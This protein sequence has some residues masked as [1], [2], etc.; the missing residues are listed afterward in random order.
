MVDTTEIFKV[1]ALRKCRNL[2]I[3]RFSSEYMTYFF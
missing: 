3:D 1:Q 2:A